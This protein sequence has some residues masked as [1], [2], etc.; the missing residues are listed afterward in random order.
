MPTGRMRGER[1]RL[2]VFHIERLDKGIILHQSHVIPVHEF[3]LER[4]AERQNNGNKY[5]QAGYECGGKNFLLMWRVNRSC[6]LR[7]KSSKRAHVKIIAEK[8]GLTCSGGVCFS[9][10]ALPYSSRHTTG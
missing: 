5:N 9:T 6:H 3:V 10:T 1:H 8:P 2:E 4:I 7:K